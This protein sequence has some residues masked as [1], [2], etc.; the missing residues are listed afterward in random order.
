MTKRRHTNSG[1]PGERENTADVCALSF[2]TEG[3]TARSHGFLRWS[4]P[5]LHEWKTLFLA[6]RP[7]YESPTAG[8]AA[9]TAER[10]FDSSMD[11]SGAMGDIPM[12]WLLRGGERKIRR[13]GEGTSQF[14]EQG[15]PA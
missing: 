10:A 5:Q 15:Q 11:G 4:A 3:F 7:L 12:V 6:C 2:L 8:A 1:H 9:S 14:G 13:F